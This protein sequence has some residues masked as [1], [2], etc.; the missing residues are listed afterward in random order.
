VTAELVNRGTRRGTRRDLQIVSVALRAA[1]AAAF[2]VA[3]APT[4]A[5]GEEASGGVRNDIGA[6]EE[7][8]A[9]LQ[10][11]V[12]ALQAQISSLQSHLAA[13]ESNPALALGPF[14]SIDPNSE[15]EVVGPNITFKGANIHIVS[16]SGFTDDND[17]PT[18]L[19]NLIVG[20]DEPPGNLS[21]TYV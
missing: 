2:L 10:A 18:G 15:N 8:V 16:G 1:I 5:R 12:S 19:G 20:Y 11:T 13:I 21:G 9:S 4:R 3:L 14:V 6:L 7:K 17:N